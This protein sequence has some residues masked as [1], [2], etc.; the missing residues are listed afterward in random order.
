ML[1]ITGGTSTETQG[2]R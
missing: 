2:T 1:A